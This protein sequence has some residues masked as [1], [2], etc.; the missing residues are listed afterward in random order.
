MKKIFDKAKIL[1][2]TQSWK[3]KIALIL[4]F[5]FLLIF[6]FS[7]FSLLY[8]KNSL[9]KEEALGKAL[10]LTQSL[11]RQ[12]EIAFY[13]KEEIFYGLGD[14]L[15]NRGVEK[16]LILDKK[17]KIL[18]PLDRF[19]EEY[20]LTFSESMDCQQLQ[21]GESYEFI[22]PLFEWIQQEGNYQKNLVAYSYLQFDLGNV[23]NQ[24]GFRFF[25]FLLQFLLYT[26]L[27]YLSFYFIKKITQTELQN[28]LVK[29][30]KYNDFN[31]ELKGE[32]KM[33]ELNSILDEIKRIKNRD[34]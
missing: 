2:E 34:D 20:T 16:A 4:S 27:F 14:V 22:C 5:L 12:N 18:A 29:L 23:V 17:G 26:C 13:L 19:G 7:A 9:L 33:E 6:F 31:E 28:F 10:S 24:N 1:F 21:K 32:Y 25:Q 30:R 11:A 3:Q 8:R 15:Q